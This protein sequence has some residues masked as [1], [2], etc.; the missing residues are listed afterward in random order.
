MGLSYLRETRENGKG[1]AVKVCENVARAYVQM[2][3]S[4]GW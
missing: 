2:K 4:V 1:T 3:L